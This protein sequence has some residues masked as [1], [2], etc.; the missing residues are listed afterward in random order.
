MR[1]NPDGT[2]P[3]KNR[4]IG[5]T[6]TV[7]LSSVLTLSVADLSIK[8]DDGDAETQS[9]D[10]SGAADEMAVTVAEAV[11][12]LT[13]ASFTGM[14]FSVDSGTGRLKCVAASGTVIQI[15]GDLAAALDFGQGVAHGGQG[16]EMINVFSDRTIS[17]TFPKNVKDKEEIDTE[18]AKGTVT[19]MII[20]AKL[21]GLSP[22]I[23]MKDKDYD[24]LELVQGGTYDRTNNTYDPPLSTRQESPKFM[25]EAFSP[26][27][28]EGNNK[29][30]DV[31]G[32][33]KILLRNCI[34][35]EG[36]VP[37]E[38]KSWATYAYNLEATEYTDENGTLMPAYQEA[39]LTESAFEALN[40]ESI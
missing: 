5:F 32:Y 16:L 10:F 3:S 4:L 29:I 18:G 26:L 14:T 22:V 13:A 23:S 31:A 1:L 17:I 6:G 37:I 7:D 35:L 12:A 20:G 19:R 27:Y 38:A 25:V 21:L 36:D 9:V 24:V 33:E 15:T 40:V 8:I 34:G 39:T 30:E 2:I 11:S 28:G